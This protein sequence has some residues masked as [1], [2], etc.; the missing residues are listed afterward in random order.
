MDVFVSNDEVFITDTKNHR[1]RKVLKNG[2]IVTIAGNGSQGYN[3]EDLPATEAQL[4]SP[5]S[6][7]VSSSDEVYICESDGN[8]IR[9]IKKDGNIVTVVG[10]GKHGYN[11]DNILA[12]D[13][14]LNCPFG[15]FVTDVGVIYIAE[16]QG[17]RIRKVQ[18]NRIISTIAGNG[19]KAFGGDNALAVNAT[20]DSPSSVTLS[21]NGEVFISEHYSNRIRKIQKDGI[22][23]TVAGTG[24]TGYNGDDQPATK[25]HIHGPAFVK[26]S[27]HG[28]VYFSE[29]YGHRIR[30]VLH[31]GTIQTVVGIGSYSPT[32]LKEGLPAQQS[33]ID[34]SG[35]F[36]TEDDECYVASSSKCCVKKIDR[37]GILTTFAGTGEQ[38]YGGDVPF[39]FKKYPHL[40]KKKQFSKREGWF[41]KAYYD[42]NFR[43]SQ[44]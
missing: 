3:G 15:I 25:A 28:E 21:P 17:H 36:L 37:N 16:W 42:M 33:Y 20:L 43:V 5:V 23:V 40:G 12:T 44:D 19:H 30:K 27:R 8:R 2:D 35:F 39:D 18:T 4:N 10:T 6:V 41:V 24:Y 1:V 29:F 9:K 38:G 31:D 34:C 26:I 13:A 32:S 11:G 14:N 22:I 7:F